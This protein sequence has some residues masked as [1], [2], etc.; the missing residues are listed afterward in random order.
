MVKK[1]K[2]GKVVK[3]GPKK[4]STKPKGKVVKAVTVVDAGDAVEDESDVGATTTAA[5]VSMAKKG[6][7]DDLVSKDLI[8]KALE[9]LKLFI[10][11]SVEDSKDSE[12]QQL[13]EDELISEI[14]L[15]LTKPSLWR[16][17]VDLKPRVI[18]LD[19]KVTEQPKIALFV[20][21]GLIDKEL[22]EK[23]EQS[24][25]N[26]SISQ[27]I[28]GQELKTTYKPY[29]KR[30]QL[31]QQFDIFLADDALITTLPK[32][33]GKVFYDSNSKVPVPVKVGKNGFNIERVQREVAKIVNGII[34]RLPRSDNLVIKLGSL[35]N[36][37]SD[38]VSQV[39]AKFA[40]E[41]LRGV[42]I[43]SNNSPALPLYESEI[44]FTKDD[45]PESNTAVVETE[46]QDNVLEIG[47][48]QVKLSSFERALV[49]L[50]HDEQVPQLLASKIKKAKKA[51]KESEKK[52]KIESK[53]LLGVNTEKSK[54][55]KK[56][57]KSKSKK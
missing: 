14:Q 3:S 24:E 20:R 35:E 29:E 23:I 44:A 38:I 9:Q 40:P 53:K 12:K 39:I 11:R 51:K 34:Y 19:R 55:V 54:V 10:D 2:S 30:R 46:S 36:V 52:E 16:S 41:S 6:S 22:L 43:K 50:A 49:E 33:L 21:D 57:G 48:E 37:N 4:T 42:F 28:A 5:V 45:L 32:L 17:K 8:E 26:N 25:L 47:G 15:Q 13:F 27:I 31:V 18:A 1:V 7:S 56:S